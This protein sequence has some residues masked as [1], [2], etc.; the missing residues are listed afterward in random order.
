MINT[1]IYVANI[2]S[3]IRIFIRVA[4]RRNYLLRDK[5]CTTYRAVLTCSKSGIYTIRRNRLVDYIGMSIG[6]NCLLHNKN[7]ITYRTVLTCS[8]TGIHTIGRNCRIYYLDMRNKIKRNAIN[9]HSSIGVR[10]ALATI[11]ARPIFYITHRGT[12]RA[13]RLV[14]YKIVN[15]TRQRISIGKQGMS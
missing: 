11:S 15:F 8:K 3:I 2:T 12:S 14:I 7:C 4:I 10:K 9:L 1:K 5:N 6:R 13:L